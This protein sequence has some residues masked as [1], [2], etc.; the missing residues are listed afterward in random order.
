MIK[1]KPILSV[2]SGCSLHSTRGVGAYQYAQYE[3]DTSA[4]VADVDVIVDDAG[5]R[6][7]EVLELE[8]APVAAR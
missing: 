1:R 7:V 3:K 2:I 6:G 8:L 5:F 4:P